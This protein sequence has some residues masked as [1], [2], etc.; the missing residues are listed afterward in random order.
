MDFRERQRF[1]VL[2]EQFI[3]GLQQLAAAA[4]ARCVFFR[5]V[6]SVFRLPERETD[7]NTEDIQTC[8]TGLQTGDHT[9][10]QDQDHQSEKNKI[11]AAKFIIIAHGRFPQIQSVLSD[12]FT[13][14]L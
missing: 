6:L 10:E 1:F 13:A 11:A 14:S 5:I 4:L 7:R 3:N 9:L 2:S 12:S 8:I